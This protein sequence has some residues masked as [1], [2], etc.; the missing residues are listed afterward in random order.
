MALRLLVTAADMDCDS[1]PP[2]A[3]YCTSAVVE[4]YR[5]CDCGVQAGQ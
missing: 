2:T 1:S 3:E 4:E 5:D